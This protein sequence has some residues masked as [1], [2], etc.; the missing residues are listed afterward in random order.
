MRILSGGTPFGCAQNVAKDPEFEKWL[1]DNGY[2]D[3]FWKHI[4]EQA[5]EK[6]KEITKAKY[7]S[8]KT[9]RQVRTK[10]TKVS[11]M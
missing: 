4:Y 8:N 7:E 2:Q 11:R 9:R 6:S 10:P 3:H 5:W 1:T